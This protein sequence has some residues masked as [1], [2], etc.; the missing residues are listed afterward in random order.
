MAIGHTLNSE[1]G[2]GENNFTVSKPLLLQPSFP[3]FARVGD[4]FEGGVLMVNYSSQEKRVSVTTR[5]SGASFKG[6]D[7]SFFVLK[8]GQS[9]EVRNNYTADK[10]GKATFIFKAKTDDDADGLQ[11]TIPINVPRIRESVAL[12]ESTTDSLTREKLV[13]PRNMYTDLGEVELTAASTAMVGLSGGISYLFTYPYGCLEQRLSAVLPIILAR[14]L[15]EAFKLEVY[16]DKD[17]RQ[18]VEKTL[19]ELQAFQR[20]NGGFSYWKNTPD[21]WPYISAYAVYTMVQATRA[22]YQ[23]N[24][25]QM[26]SGMDYLRRVLDG[27]E[28]CKYY[29]ESA[30]SCT[31]ALILYT[32]ALAGKPDFGLMEKLYGERSKAPL[33][34]KAYL[35]RALF[36]AKGNA[37]MMQE[38]ARDLTNQAKVA[39]ASAHFE[40]RN[41]QG[42]DWIFDSNIRTTALTMQALVETQPENSILPKV[43][44]WLLEKRERGCW[45]TTQENLYVVDAL[46]TYFKTY[47]KDEP[48]FRVEIDLAGKTVLKEMF[49]GRNFRTVTARQPWAGLDEGKEY[50]VEMKRDGKGRLYYGVRMNYYPK[51]SSNAREEGFSIIKETEQVTGVQ[52]TP[53]IFA[54]GSMIRVTISVVTNQERHFVVVDD[55]LPAGFEAV[56]SS[57]LTTASNVNEYRQQ[58]ERDW[59]EF[60]PFDHVEMKDDR[61]LLFGDYLPA[62][63]HSYTYLARAT[64]FGTFNVPSTRVEGMY[65]PEV[66]G[67][68]GERIVTI[69]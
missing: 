62:G 30:W 61:V 36:A 50:D 55:P 14:D 23:V 43:V 11:W 28:P 59:W 35:L 38:L 16:K 54:A 6:N 69:R 39:P 56:N 19:D 25:G 60:D 10:V 45:R 34:A 53:G 40:E 1:F 29:S 2:Y 52:G 42:M 8:P 65:E 7:S 32:F 20:W 4:K 63:I 44:R 49:E 31:R 22:G 26:R 13:V 37:A 51:A 64:S 18:V 58:G 12:Y 21:T 66:F 15:V 3:R 57:F 17:Y 33:F 48:D 46:A 27:A 9:L 41:D 47:E 5:T 24:Q 68:T 67:Q